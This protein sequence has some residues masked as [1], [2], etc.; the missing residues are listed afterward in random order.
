MWW[1]LGLLVFCVALA[2]QPAGA[3]V[4]GHALTVS[5]RDRAGAGV[6][7]AVVSAR[8]DAGGGD[9]ARGVTAA[10]GEVRLAG[11]PGDAV[12]VLVAGRMSDGARLALRGADARGILVWLSAPSARLDLRA[13]PGGGLTP[14]PATMISPD[15]PVAE[16]GDLQISLPSPT[17]PPGVVASSPRL[18]PQDSGPNWAG[19]VVLLSGLLLGA[20]VAIW[21][22]VGRAQ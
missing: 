13:E 3:R 15:A 1:R 9:L 2:P 20:L 7:G 16:G 5:I 4:A 17:P 14:D 8:D 18:A 21:S 22:P 11:L 12:R 10:S 19:L 6:A